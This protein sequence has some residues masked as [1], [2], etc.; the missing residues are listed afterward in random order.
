MIEEPQNHYVKVVISGEKTDTKNH[1]S[2]FMPSWTPGSYLMREYARHVRRFYAHT[3]HGE[4]L[5][6]FQPSKGVWTLDWEKSNLH[7]KSNLFQVSYEV[8]CHE[9]GVR[10]SHVDADH[11]FI[12]GPSVFMG[13]LE[14][15]S[16]DITVQVEF[17]PV[18]SKIST[19]LKDVSTKRNKFIYFASD[20]DTLLDSPLEIGCHE[21][22]GF[23]LEGVDHELAFSGN[24]IPHK[25]DFK[26]DI[27]TICTMVAKTMGEIPCQ[28]YTF[29]SYF[30][31][32]KFGGLEHSNSTALQYCPKKLISRKGYIHWLSLVAHEYFHTW[33]GKRIRP[34]ELGPFNYQKEATTTMLW[35]VEGLTSF[36]DDLFVYRSG[37]CTLEEYLEMQ[38]KKLDRYWKTPGRAFS[39]LDDSS[40]NAWIKLY[41]PDENSSNAFIS[42]Y[43]KGG[44][45][46]WVLN[47]LLFEQ[48]KSID[49][50]LQL[51]WKRYKERPELGLVENEVFQMVKDLGG[52]RVSESF[53]NM[54]KT[55]EEI[56][57][58]GIFQL[59]GLGFEWEPLAEESV[60][61]GADFTFSGDCVWVKSVILDGPAYKSGI[62]AGDEI[63]ALNGMRVLRQHGFQEGEGLLPGVEYVVTVGRLQ[64][65]KELVLIPGRPPRTLKKIVVLDEKKCEKALKNMV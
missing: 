22:D 36:M 24:L 13:I 41:R 14:E 49:E 31:L 55:T 48:G 42:Y 25:H 51:L 19:G 40:F 62:S 6:F 58:E 60:Y 56:D 4:I 37:L 46:F 57:L 16:K 30:A 61:L 17:P 52:D 54:V 33:N 50:L 47:A 23:V 44:I 32:G 64:Q 9:F 3:S 38:C 35:L 29:L 5:W 27:K 26:A 28:K 34:K 53:I 15:L 45:A 18:W 12:H 39:S 59:V 20:Y 8:Y 65:L 1:L 10:N 63:I 7:K 43:L 21:T 11:A 2:F